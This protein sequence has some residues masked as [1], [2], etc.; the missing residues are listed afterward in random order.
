MKL[1]E[2]L[3]CIILGVF[4]IVI[5]LKW[6]CFEKFKNIGLTFLHNETK[7]EQCCNML[8]NNLKCENKCI[9]GGD[10]CSCCYK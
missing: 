2:T 9:F 6:P 7:C 8:N 4:F 3:F 5:L 1:E 10:I